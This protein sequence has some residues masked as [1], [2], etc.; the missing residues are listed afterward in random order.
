MSKRK[1]TLA[2]ILLGFRKTGDSL[3][4]R[5]MKTGEDVEHLLEMHQMLETGADGKAVLVER[6][7]QEI[8]AIRMQQLEMTQKLS[9]IHSQQQAMVRALNLPA[10]LSES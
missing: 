2:A 7:F 10:E 4:D 6:I 9:E 8:E 1:T 3:L 5:T